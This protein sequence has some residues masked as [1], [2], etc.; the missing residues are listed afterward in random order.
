MVASS[1]LSPW[2]FPLAAIFFPLLWVAVAL[3]AEP[4]V[5]SADS[6]PLLSV[7]MM[8]LELSEDVARRFTLAERLADLGLVLSDAEAAKMAEFS[9]SKPEGGNAAAAPAR[10]SVGRSTMLRGAAGGRNVACLILPEAASSDGNITLRVVPVPAS[11]SPLEIAADAPS[12]M[13]ALSRTSAIVQLKQGES[14]MFGGW[15]A[16]KDQANTVL[17]IVKPRVVESAGPL[18]VAGKSSASTI[19][20]GDARIETAAKAGNSPNV[21]REVAAADSPATAPASP[22]PVAQGPVPSPPTPAR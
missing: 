21:A 12:T 15:K 20:L 6:H 18:G 10:T 1:S 8:L 2:R 9:L 3:G 5:G 19:R 7:E 17:A 16:G 14:M 4:P 11:R 22:G 13:F